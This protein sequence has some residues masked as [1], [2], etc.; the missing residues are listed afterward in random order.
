MRII[1]ASILVNVALLS[2]IAMRPSLAPPSVEAIL[3]R[4]FH[5]GS[6]V[7]PLKSREVLL[8]PSA[9]RRGIPEPVPIKG[10]ALGAFF[11]TE[12]FAVMTARM[13][14]AGFPA[15]VI[16][17]I[18]RREV[19]ARYEARINAL[20]AL[21]PNTPFWKTSPDAIAKANRIGVQ[22]SQLIQEREKA[23]RDAVNDPFFF[24]EAALD[25]GQR[26]MWGDLPRTKLDRIQRIEDDYADMIANARTS[27]NGILLAEDRQKL[28][29]LER[30]KQT[31]IAALLSPEE[32]AEY[33]LRTGAPGVASRL[34]LFNP[35]EAEYRIIAQATGEMNRNGQTNGT[36]PA[37]PDQRREILQS[38][39]TQL[40]AALGS[41][42]YAELVLT[43]NPEFQYLS[44]AAEAD[45]LPAATVRQAFSL[46]DQVVQE[47]N[48]IFDNP[49]LDA[50][51]KRTA[52][53][54]LAQNTRNQL[55]S[56]LGPSSG[57]E[58]LKIAESWLSNVANGS[59]VSFVTNG[60]L[61]NVSP[62][63]RRLPVAPAA[64]PQ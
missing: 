28:E 39:E 38:F 32:L 43:S 59:A 29:L 2:A 50:A 21:D 58:Y 30:E 19:D 6:E 15:G 23:Y 8:S 64:R 37:T 1:A 25:I 57:P 49:A 17:E 42:R 10:P 13:R 40:K 63:F 41:S 4:R 34:R 48:R 9:V 47:S 61:G 3:V 20:T 11:A 16:A 12:D 44:Q 54:Q 51:Q 27:A 24:Q 33:K 52:L 5:L 60:P 46:R 18:A 53:Q 56:T 45:H 14:A 26:R 62:T 36:P 7:A 35:T 22:M 55:L 31:D